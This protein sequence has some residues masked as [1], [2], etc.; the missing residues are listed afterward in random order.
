MSLQDFFSNAVAFLLTLLVF[1]YLLGDNPLY[2]FALHVFVGVAAGYASAVVFRDVLKPRLYDA[3][4]AA[5]KE[6]VERQNWTPLLL[7]ALLTLLALLVALKLN[8]GLAPYGNI[9]IAFV[10]GVG[11]AVAVGGAVTG[12]LFPQI[13]ASWVSPFASGDPGDILNT[14]IIIISTLLALMYFF[15]SGRSMP[16]GK[17]ERPGAVRVLAFGGQAII[18][19]TLAALYVG[20]LAA[21]LALFTE[22]LGFLYRFS[23]E[24]AKFF[25]FV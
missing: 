13:K 20:A 22:R 6:Y 4:F 9:A 3:W 10:V 16:G 2:R 12:T 14:P 17:V 8:S 7:I 24:I 25:G 5:G 23:L 15:Y 1:S 18:T 11:A 19:V 21:S